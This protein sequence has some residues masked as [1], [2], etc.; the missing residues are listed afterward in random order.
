MGT[1]NQ[2]QLSEGLSKAKKKSRS[3]LNKLEPFSGINILLLVSLILI[4]IVQATEYC[5][6]SSDQYRERCTDESLEVSYET[7]Y[8]THTWSEG[9]IYSVGESSKQYC[10]CSTPD[11]SRGVSICLSGGYC[12]TNY[13]S[14]CY[15]TDGIYENTMTFDQ[16]MQ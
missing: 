3:P 10:R 14:P 16:C 9:N 6:G 8:G 11:Y 4:D 5:C 12:S 7:I 1:A 13:D 2:Y 15:P